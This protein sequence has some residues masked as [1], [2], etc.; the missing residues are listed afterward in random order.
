MRPG[1]SNSFRAAPNPNSVL[2]ARAALN[3]DSECPTGM[4]VVAF[5]PRLRQKMRCTMR[6]VLCSATCIDT[7]GFGETRHA[8]V[9]VPFGSLLVQRDRYDTYWGAKKIIFLIRDIDGPAMAAAS[10]ESCRFVTRR[11]PGCRFWSVVGMCNR[12]RRMRGNFHR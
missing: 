12:L 2:G 3:L 1:A 9:R 6:A 5:A 7:L 10:M 11:S 4:L 8:A